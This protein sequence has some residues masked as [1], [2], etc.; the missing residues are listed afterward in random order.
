VSRI[1]YDCKLTK[2]RN[3]T[4]SMRELSIQFIQP[5]GF[6]FQ[7]GQFIMMQVPDPEKGKPTQRAYSLASD[8]RTPENIRL[9][10]KVYEKG[11]ASNFVRDLKGGEDLKISG[12]FGR[13]F[14]HQPVP[15]KVNF[16]CTGA[17]I[18]Q[19]MSYL[20][21]H[22][23]LMKNSR[24]KMLLGVWNQEEI[25]YEEEL[26]KVKAAIPGFQLDYVLDKAD[27]SWKGKTGFVTQYFDELQLD[28]NSLVY[29]CGNPN[30]IK[31]AKETLVL[32]YNFPADKVIAEAFN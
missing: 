2:I 13:H 6:K 15:P 7:A 31:S 28:S 30:M 19:H 23:A 9:V 3:L 11:K 16:V 12:P 4:P 27:P 26:A 14:F 21:S 8:D 22:P 24:V 10:I 32:K 20:L 1:L 29:L 25:F 5:A 17:G 18:S